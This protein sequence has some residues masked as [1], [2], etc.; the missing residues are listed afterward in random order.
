MKRQ[1]LQYGAMMVGLLLGYDSLAWSQSQAAAPY[2]CG[3]VLE[4]K[5]AIREVYGPELRILDLQAGD[6]IADIGGSNG[7]RMGMFAALHDSLHIYIE[8]ID[9]LCLNQLELDRVLAWYTH[10]RGQPL[11][12][13]FEIVVG[14][15]SETRLPPL[16][17][18]KVL[19]TAAYHHFEQPGPMI[20][21]IVG[22]LRS[23]GKIY[24]IENVARRH[25]QRRRRLCD[26]VLMTEAELKL[27]FGAHNLR[28]EGVHPLGRWWTKMFVLQPMAND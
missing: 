10:V 27:A 2:Q 16:T 7:Y 11:H 25:G 18:D 1:M 17:F 13:T 15:A 21:D 14:T 5:E 28:V 12:S 22:K 8:D 23:G 3:F 4:T 26:D 24:L 20:A 19:V 6:V 9:T